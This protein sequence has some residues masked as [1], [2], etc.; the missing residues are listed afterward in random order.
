MIH[1]IVWQAADHPFVGLCCAYAGDLRVRVDHIG[2]E[3]G[4][5]GSGLTGVVDEELVTSVGL[6]FFYLVVGGEDGILSTSS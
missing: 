2:E 4:D 3:S 6:V 5:R 1:V